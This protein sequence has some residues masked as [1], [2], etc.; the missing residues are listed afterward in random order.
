MVVRGAFL[1]KRWFFLPLKETL[2]YAK[3]YMKRFCFGGCTDYPAPELHDRAPEEPPEILVV[4][5]QTH[6]E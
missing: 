1:D 3:Q 2:F 6:D 5:N 4:K